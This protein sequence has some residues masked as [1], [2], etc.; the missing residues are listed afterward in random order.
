LILYLLTRKQKYISATDARELSRW[1]Y[2]FSLPL[3][4]VTAVYPFFF[5]VT[6]GSPWAHRSVI[7]QIVCAPTNLLEKVLPKKMNAWWERNASNTRSQ[8]YGKVKLW[9]SD[10]R[11]AW[12]QGKEDMK[13]GYLG[14]KKQKDEANVDSSFL[15][16]QVGL[17]A[18]ALAIFG[19]IAFA[20]LTMK[21]RL[22]LLRFYLRDLHS[23]FRLRYA[24]LRN[25]GSH[26][27]V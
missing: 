18:L 8:I 21:F 20:G 16:A 27:N 6:Y 15:W 7:G 2:D 23:A 12:Q 13:Y 17:Y 9:A 22:F 14:R 11:K 3:M 19:W 5:Q 1:V 24:T 25:A 4:L 26:R 10:P